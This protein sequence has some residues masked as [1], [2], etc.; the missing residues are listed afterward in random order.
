MIIT[1]SNEKLHIFKSNDSYF[2]V[3]EKE[4][5]SFVTADGKDPTDIMRRRLK[6]MEEDIE[7]CNF[8]LKKMRGIRAIFGIMLEGKED[9]DL[10]EVVIVNDEE[11]TTPA[12]KLKFVDNKL[13]LLQKD[14]GEMSDLRLEFCDFMITCGIPP[15]KDDT[16]VKETAS[17]F[18][19]INKGSASEK[20]ED[21]K[22]E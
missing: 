4:D 21:G 6:Y 22:E 13:S 10:G 2:P 16:S 19:K 9:I 5:G 1:L 12:Q 20:L 8:H 7:N 17:L 3:I 18:S 11:L 14:L 15:S